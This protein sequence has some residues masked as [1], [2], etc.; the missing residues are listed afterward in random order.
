MFVQTKCN[1]TS[2]KRYNLMKSAQWCKICLLTLL[3][4][5]VR[6]VTAAPVLAQSIIQADDGTGT[7]VTQNG[8]Q[9][10]IIGGTLSND[11]ANLFHSFQELGINSEQ[12]ANFMATPDLRNILGRVIG[13]NPSIID[14]LIQ[15]TGGTANLYLMNPA[16][17]IFGANA[18]LNVPANFT[19]TTATG[20]GFGNDW[21][22]A[23]GDNNYQNL[24][25]DPSQFAFDLSQRGII[26]NAGELAVAPGRD[27]ALLGGQVVNTGTLTA[28]GGTI[29]IA[30][31]PNSR[32]VKISQSG[33]VLSFEVELPRNNE[34]LALPTNPLDLATLLTGPVNGVETGVEV[35]NSGE[36]QTDSGE[37]IPNQVGVAIASGTVESGTGHISII[38]RGGTQENNTSGIFGIHIIDDSRV[39]TIGEGTITLNGTGGSGGNFSP[40]ILGNRGISINNATVSS[41]NG[42]IHLIGTGGS[43]DN[44][45]HYGV[46][47]GSQGGIVQ[48]TGTGTIIIE[49]TGGN[50]GEGTLHGSQG[51]KVD[52]GGLVST[53]EGDIQFIGEGGIG[54]DQFNHGV[55]LF[56][57]SIVEVTGKGNITIEGTAGAGITENHGIRIQEIDPNQSNLSRITAR[58]GAITLIGVGKGTGDSNYGI[59]LRGGGVETT[60]G[61]NLTLEGIGANGAAGINVQ[62]G[63]IQASGT[64]ESTTTLIADDIRVVDTPDILQTPQIQGTGTVALSPLD[65]T[66]DITLGDTSDSNSNTWNLDIDKL[67]LF[68]EGFEQLVIGGEDN[69]GTITLAD[70]ITFKIPVIL[71]SL[72]GSGA[73]DTTGFTLTG[74]QDATITLQA[75]QQITTGSI[76]N[77]GRAITLTSNGSIDTRSGILDSHDQTNNG[78]AISLSAVQD[79]TTGD[80]DASSGGNGQGATITLTSRDGEIITND[81]NS[82]GFS[83]GDILIDAATAIT[84]GKIN[85]SGTISNGGNVTL[86]PIGDIQ[87]T[88]INAQ[89]GNSGQGGQVDSTAGQFFR[90]T[91]TFIDQNGINASISTAGGLGGDSITLRHGGDGVIPFIVG[92]GITNGTRG[93][94]TNGDFTISPTQSFLFTHQVGNIQIISVDSPPMPV[95]PPNLPPESPTS[96]TNAAINPV[97][98]LKPLTEPTLPPDKDEPPEIEIDTQVAQWEES[99]T[100]DY[101]AYLGLQDTAI[102]TLADARAT[103]HRIEQATGAKPALIY[104]IF[105]PTTV[106]PQTRSQDSKSSAQESPSRNSDQLEIILVTAKGQLIRHPIPGA[107][108]EKVM[109]TAD[110]LR[111]TVTDTHIP[112]PYQRYAQQFY[113][114][115]IAPLETELKTQEINNLAFIMDQ[116]LRSLPL[117]VLHDGEQFMIERYSIGVMPSLS[118]TDTRYRDVRNLQ[119]LAMGASKFTDQNPLPAVPTE[120]SAIATQLWQG[121]LF[122]NETFTAANLKRARASQPFGIIHLATHG[123]FKSGK[124]S[125]SYIQFWDRKLRLSDIRQLGLHDPS[126]ELMVLSACRT[127]LGDEEAELGFTGLAVQAGV[128]SALG[129][130]WYVSDEGTLGLMTGFY[131]QL[132]QSPLKAEALRQAQLAMIRGQV[133]LEE[134]YLI[135]PNHRIALPPELAN[136]PNKELTH[137]YY[138]SAFTLVGSPW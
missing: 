4:E 60:A 136:L 47:I 67:N 89:G 31:V 23:L 12:I 98:L 131:E 20:I 54:P 27:L 26:I 41:Q 6:L 62:D 121:K 8:N 135:T 109:D 45:L 35:T 42:I 125:S 65:P 128:K 37:I 103:L 40:D 17:I 107:T 85:S 14:G 72:V 106:A 71:R 49:G 9:F 104:A 56:R 86:D 87:V 77:P 30:A 126:A 73:I 34:G 108:R 48:S 122:L 24:V 64:G 118:L 130:L 46:S 32:L 124:P 55:E 99:L 82:S 90:A 133:R 51:I 105:V 44:G 39:E 91:G 61:G 33:Q 94:I 59:D 100:R 15:V 69:Q 43:G 57:G 5:M 78:G 117:A 13:E 88:F 129:S 110:K 66:V 2:A 28:S 83:G 58:D 138:W 22:N 137:P 38:G 114:W 75:N 119:V 120:L 36:I 95:T 53:R 1:Y 52:L 76:I 7:S 25:G 50:G 29:T 92:D 113:Q 132:Q 74:T 111:R 115:L 80:I 16:G 102:L 134:G 18:Q 127:A 79:I 70:D 10:D 68:Q 84:T 97:N 3:A 21:F 112:R 93:T 11:G 123:E 96:E 116:G 19:A 63:F 101:E 81:L